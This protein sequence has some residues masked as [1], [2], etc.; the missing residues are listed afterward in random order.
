MDTPVLIIT[1]FAA[2]LLLYISMGKESTVDRNETVTHRYQR[3]P[4]FRYSPFSH[5]REHPYAQF[6]G[7]YRY[8]MFNEMRASYF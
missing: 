8:P 2:A 4:D 7:D 6:S 3:Y 1:F 5:N